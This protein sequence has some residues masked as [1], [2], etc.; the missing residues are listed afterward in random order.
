MDPFTIRKAT[1]QDAPAIAAIYNE[2]MEERVATFN[3]EHVTENERRNRIEKGGDRHPVFV[4][5]ANPSGEVAGWASISEYNPRPC[6]AGIGEISVYVKK[7]RRGRGLG[8]SLLQTLI[9]EAEPRGY[10]KLMGRIF[11][12]NQVSRNLCMELGFREIGVHEKHGKLDGRW[13][14]VVEVERL[15]PQ[16]II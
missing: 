7:E 2:G 4:A 10:W 5:V 12:F 3:T 9:A 11:V 15:I 13:I 6:Y 8:K 1:L 14:D 16:N